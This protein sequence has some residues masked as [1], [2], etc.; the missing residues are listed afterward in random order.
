MVC[1]SGLKAVCLGAQSIM[2]GEST[3]VVAGGMENM[4]KVVTSALYYLFFFMK[5]QTDSVVVLHT[6]SSHPAHESRCEDGR[7]LP[8]G[9]RGVRWPD[10]RLS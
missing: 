10:G 1:G 9:L 3:V 5:V 8:A 2:S 6:G 4:S 7:R